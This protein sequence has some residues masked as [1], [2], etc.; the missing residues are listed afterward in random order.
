MD[1]L[2][3]PSLELWI[4]RRAFFEAVEARMRG[5]GSYLVSEQAC[6]LTA[7]VQ[8]A[9]C[10]GAWVAVQVLALA[11]VDASLRETEA[12][13]FTGNTAAII[14]E[15]SASP[16]LHDV[17]RRRNRLVHLDPVNPAIT[18]DQQWADR[19]T[20]E[21]QAREAVELMFEAFYHSPGT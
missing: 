17:R 18:V 11:V 15:C 5:D 20:L 14:D 12:P 13:G 4:D 9:F 16:R 7:D 6:A 2:E 19:A 1:H 10:A 8:A 3:H 21:A